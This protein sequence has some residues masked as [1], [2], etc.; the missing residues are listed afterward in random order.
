MS[1]L[2]QESDTYIDNNV[3]LIESSPYYNSK[4]SLI[5]TNIKSMLQ[6]K[7]K[8]TNRSKKDKEYFRELWVTY[9]NILGQPLSTDQARNVKVRY[10]NLLEAC[11]ILMAHTGDINSTYGE[12]ILRNKFPISGMILSEVSNEVFH[13]LVSL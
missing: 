13:K 3:E 12:L 9:S 10:D 5:L 7:N 8:L 2:K 11:T 1:V 6:L 4:Y